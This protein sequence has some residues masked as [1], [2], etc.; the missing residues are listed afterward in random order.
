MQAVWARNAGAVAAPPA[1][2]HF[3]DALLAALAAKGVAFTHVTLRIGTGTFP[4]GE[5]GC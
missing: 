5:W 4:A 1:S 3:D 2:L